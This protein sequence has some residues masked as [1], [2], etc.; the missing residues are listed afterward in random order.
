M[1]LKNHQ[2]DESAISPPR[3]RMDT[4]FALGS[5]AGEANPAVVNLVLCAGGKYFV[6]NSIS[7]GVLQF[8]LWFNF[9]CFPTL[10]AREAKA[11]VDALNPGLH[12]WMNKRL[13]W[14]D[15]GHATM[16]WQT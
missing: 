4:S 2:L 8:W 10:A 16:Q 9:G 14:V 13:V 1:Y 7:T 15:K 6:L 3:P 12:Y 5:H 11:I